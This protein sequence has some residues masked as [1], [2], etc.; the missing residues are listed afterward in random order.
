MKKTTYIA[1]IFFLTVLL[2][3]PFKS[4]LA[5]DTTKYYLAADVSE[6]IIHMNV[7]EFTYEKD[8][9]S[10]NFSDSRGKIVL[11]NLW[12][13]WCG[14]C[15]S[16]IPDLIKIYDEFGKDNLEILGILVADKK[17]NL[18]EFL[19]HNKINYKVIYGN[20]KL[21][22][23]ISRSINMKIE[24]IP[25]TIIVDENGLIKKTLTG[26]RTYEEFKTILNNL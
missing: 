10:F 4:G 14:P 20:E 16:E 8:G 6:E 22:S 12:A 19:L 1:I 5:G 25:F 24:S 15:I 23:A 26:S 7:P 21:I 17:E 2:S 9:V 11:I 13:T 3:L 18:V